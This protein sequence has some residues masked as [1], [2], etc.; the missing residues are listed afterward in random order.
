MSTTTKSMLKSW[1]GTFVAAVIAAL[2]A[3][4]TTT[5]EIPMD[6]QTW[7]AI[8]VS[9]LV[10]VLPVVKNYFDTSYL[11]YGKVTLSE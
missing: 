5:G 1:A 10:S 2:M 4:L 6:V 7:L 9:G 11:N 3:I 8:L